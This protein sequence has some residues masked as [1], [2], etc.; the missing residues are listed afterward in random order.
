VCTSVIAGAGTSNIKQCTVNGLNRPQIVICTR[1]ILCIWFDALGI[2]VRVIFNCI[3]WFQRNG[4]FWLVV[5]IVS[6]LVIW[7]RR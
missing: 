1:D 4:G 7:G 2:D 5:V 6:E 3:L